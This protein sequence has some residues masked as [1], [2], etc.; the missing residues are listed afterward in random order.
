MNS[1]RA[2]R[3]LPPPRPPRAG[4]VLLLVL[5]VMAIILSTVF[6]AAATFR[7][8]ARLTRDTLRREAVR[9]ELLLCISNAVEVLLADTNAIDHLGE[10]WA[11]P[12]GAPP[13][14]CV[15]TDE[16][17]RLPL[18]TADTNLLAAALAGAPESS[19]G[20][21]AATPPSVAMGSSPGSRSNTTV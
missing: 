6:L 19:A 2:P 4:G 9:D 5:C 12:L 13:L 1:A 14:R 20:G 8:R 18:Q 3:A 16:N 15:L 11:A 10:P 17:A 21:S 7:A